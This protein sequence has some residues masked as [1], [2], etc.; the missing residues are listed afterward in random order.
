M[1]HHLQDIP[2][3][4]EINVSTKDSVKVFKYCVKDKNNAVIS[5][6]T[7]NSKKDAENNAALEAL[8]HFNVNISTLNII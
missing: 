1:Q 5:T 3:F 6:A 4:L 8:K 7:G 2:K